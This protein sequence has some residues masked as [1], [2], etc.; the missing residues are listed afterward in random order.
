MRIWLSSFLSHISNAYTLYFHT[1]KNLCEILKCVKFQNDFYYITK[2]NNMLFTSTF[3]LFLHT[4]LLQI[5][6]CLFIQLFHLTDD[7]QLVQFDFFSLCRFCLTQQKI[8]KENVSEKK[9]KALSCTEYRWQC[10]PWGSQKECK[11]SL[12]INGLRLKTGWSPLVPKS[13]IWKCSQSQGVKVWWKMLYQEA[14]FCA[15]N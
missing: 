3:P 15:Q 2:T 13:K 14:L 4:Y 1:K 7:L 9:A 12:S 5:Q 10:R 8:K 6:F 11:F